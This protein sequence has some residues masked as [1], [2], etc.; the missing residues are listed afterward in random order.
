MIL[1]LSFGVQ[2]LAI[3]TLG[4]YVARIYQEVKGRPLYIVHRHLGEGLPQDG[5]IT[6]ATPPETPT[7]G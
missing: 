2:M 7:A 1:L 6:P 4:E 3:G 5:G